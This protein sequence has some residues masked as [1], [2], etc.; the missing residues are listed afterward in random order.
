MQRS[1]SNSAGRTRRRQIL[2]AALGCFVRRGFEATTIEQIRDA[3]GASH[4]SIYHH[5]GNKE[6]I[7]LALFVEG[8]HAYQDAVR[9]SF[10]KASTAEA[11]VR[12]LIAAHLEWVEV[13]ES[14][15]RFL[16]RMS[17]A[18]FSE[19]TM[20]R[21]AAVNQEFFRAVHGWLVPFIERGEVVRLPAALYVP[22]L[23]GPAAHY[24]RHW[25]AHRLTLDR[26]EVVTVLARAAWESLRRQ[27]GSARKAR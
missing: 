14:R 19:E 1:S 17:A 12:A 10:S 13:H 16:T 9:A 23:L 26:A 22:L 25:L 4:G 6:G 24:A 11:G 21:I 18:E 2:D 20:E 5:F 8:M 7:A 3:S 15:S 27:E